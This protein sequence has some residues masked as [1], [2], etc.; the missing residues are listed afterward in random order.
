MLGNYCR[1]L[2]II[3]TTARHYGYAALYNI[4]SLLQQIMIEDTV[5]LHTPKQGIATTSPVNNKTLMNF[6]ER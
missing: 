1:K 2:E 5:E 6:V 3:F 4:M